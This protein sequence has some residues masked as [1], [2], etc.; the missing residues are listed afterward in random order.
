MT[1][2][3]GGGRKLLRFSCLKGPTTSSDNNDDN[4]ET[5]YFLQYF[6]KSIL[7][8]FR[9]GEFVANCAGRFFPGSARVPPF[10]L[11]LSISSLKAPRSS[12]FLGNNFAS[13]DAFVRFPPPSLDSFLRNFCSTQCSSVVVVVRRNSSNVFYV[14]KCL[15]RFFPFFVLCSRKNLF[16]SLL[17]QRRL[18]VNQAG[19]VFSPQ[20]GEGKGGGGGEESSCLITALRGPPLG[21]P[22][23]SPP[24]LSV[25][26][27]CKRDRRTKK[28]VRENNVDFENIFFLYFFKYIFCYIF[29]INVVI[30]VRSVS[31]FLTLLHCRIWPE[32]GVYFPSPPLSPTQV[33]AIPRESDPSPFRRQNG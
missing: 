15:F 26:N 28:K 17:M 31:Y 9:H 30:V 20:G 3:R 22:S 13:S 2:N 11:L 8:K 29:Q 27:Y 21:S 10:L 5:G 14:A 7:G 16:P 12:P 25:I 6:L 4:R 33:G 23:P 19:G 18:R 32:L 1:T 24:C